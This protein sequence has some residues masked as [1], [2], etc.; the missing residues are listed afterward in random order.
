MGISEVKSPISRGRTS[1][2]PLS[3]GARS[4][5]GRGDNSEEPVHH[6]LPTHPADT[7]EPAEIPGGSAEVIGPED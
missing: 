4:N 7:D 3:P 5:P 1:G 2:R 6:P